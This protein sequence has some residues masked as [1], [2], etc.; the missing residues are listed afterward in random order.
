MRKTILT[1]ASAALLLFAPAA[2]A[3]KLQKA[4]VAATIAKSTLS[5]SPSRDWNGIGG[6]QGKQSEVWTID[7]EKLN[8]LI[9]YVGIKDG[10]ALAPKMK[11]VVLPMWQQKTLLVELPELFESTWRATRGV[12]DFAQ[13][14]STPRQFLGHEGIAFDYEYAN[15]DNLHVRG[16]AV[17]TIIDGQL[18]M[19]ALNAPRLNYFDRVKP[20]FDAI[21]ASAKLN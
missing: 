12:T 17:A 9:F 4:G 20:A 19:I 7:G 10:T 2:Q 16:S 11:K 13:L 15:A 1:A 21:V 3:H 8:E 18:Y 5:V 6:R 14:S